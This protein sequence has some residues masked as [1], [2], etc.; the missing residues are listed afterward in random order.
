[1]FLD[2]LRAYI[3]AGTSTDLTRQAALTTIQEMIGDGNSPIGMQM[4]PDTLATGA[5]MPALTYM[6]VDDGTDH[7]LD[8]VSDGLYR[9]RVQ[10]DVWADDPGDRKVLGLALKQALDGLTNLF[11]GSTDLNTLMWSNEIDTYE[12]ERKQYRKML[13]FTVQ[14]N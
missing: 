14:H 3:T 1:M 11:F 4:F 7:I 8:G 9:P 5:V 13:D 12:P 2:D 6:L 10:I